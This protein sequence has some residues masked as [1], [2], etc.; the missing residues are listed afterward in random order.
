[1]TT[2][3]AMKEDGVNAFLEQH[4]GPVGEF[5]KFSKDAKFE[6]ISDGEEIKFGT[7]LIC[8][9]PETQHGW[10]KF[11]GAGQP[12]TRHMGGMFNGYVPPP[13]GELGDDD[14]TLWEVG[15]SGKPQ[16][17]WKAQVL[18]P[19]KEV[20]GD[21]LYIFQTSSTTGLRAVASLISE[22]K[23]MAKREPDVYPV[24]ELAVGA[25]EHKDP[26][27]GTVK[28]PGFKVVGKVSRNGVEPPQ[29]GTAATLND[30]IPW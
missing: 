23:Q 30:E 1:M 21:R 18:L 8:V 2:L 27:V 7:K 29:I 13:R 9:F 3:P 19:L 11:N 25:F 5:I 6:R 15:L 24:V 26:R 12:P 14:P 22:C 28:K 17:P 10:V 20:D 4:G 16:D